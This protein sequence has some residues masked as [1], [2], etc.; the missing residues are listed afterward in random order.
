[1]GA[2]SSRTAAFSHDWI[3]CPEFAHTLLQAYE[4]EKILRHVKLWRESGDDDDSD[5]TEIRGPPGDLLPAED[6]PDDDWAGW[7]APPPLDWT[8]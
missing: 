7:D 2:A 3:G 1:M 4:V 8:A 6:Q 5:I